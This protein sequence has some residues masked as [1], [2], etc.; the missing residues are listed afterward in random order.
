MVRV[1]TNMK[2]ITDREMMNSKYDSVCNNH[3]SHILRKDKY[4]ILS[5]KE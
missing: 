1:F 5:K 3:S 4:A 2:I